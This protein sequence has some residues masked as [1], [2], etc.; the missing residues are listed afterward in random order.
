[1]AWLLEGVRELKEIV[2]KQINEDVWVTRMS[3]ILLETG[4]WN[5]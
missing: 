3:N 2:T 4:E 5:F 1:M